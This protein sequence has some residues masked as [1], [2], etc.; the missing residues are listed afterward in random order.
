MSNPILVETV[1]GTMVES[2]HRGTVAVGVQADDLAPLGQ[3]HRRQLAEHPVAGLERQRVAVDLR[4]VV[5]VERLVDR[6]Q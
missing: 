2:R 6:G 4:R 5:R 3:R 1:R